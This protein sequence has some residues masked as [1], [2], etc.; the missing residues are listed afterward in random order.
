M[1]LHEAGRRSLIGTA[2]LASYWKF[3]CEW[4]QVYFRRLAGRTA[5]WTSDPGR[6]TLPVHERLP[7]G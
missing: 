7:G 3:A 2:A 1:T 6:P 5:L 4:Q